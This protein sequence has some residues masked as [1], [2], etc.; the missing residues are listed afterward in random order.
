MCY[1]GAGISEPLSRARQLLP[2]VIRALIPIL[3]IAFERTHHNPHQRRIHAGDAFLQRYRAGRQHAVIHGPERTRKGL[4]PG[5][6]LVEH[7]ANGEDV[8]SLID[9]LTEQLLW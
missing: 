2:H 1:G 7:R 5:N 3:R 8:A 4:F 9:H 6:D